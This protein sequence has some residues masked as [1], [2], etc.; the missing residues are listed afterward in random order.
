MSKA[1]L[2]AIQTVVGILGLAVVYS[3]RPPSGF[4]EALM[5]LGQGKHQYIKEPLYE[6]LFGGLRAHVRFWLD[7]DR[8]RPEET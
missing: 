6:I 8:Y 5:M 3:V 7:K 1:T 2:G 4:G